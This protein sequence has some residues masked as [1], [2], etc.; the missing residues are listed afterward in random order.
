MAA[1]LGRASL[2]LTAGEGWPTRAAML[3]ILAAAAAG[4]VDLENVTKGM[5]QAAHDLIARSPTQ[6]GE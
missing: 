3:D 1:A 6:S 5:A 4:T 2:V